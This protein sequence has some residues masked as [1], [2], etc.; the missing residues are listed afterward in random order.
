MGLNGSN[1]KKI[2]DTIFSIF[3][4]GAHQ[5]KCKHTCILIYVDLGFFDDKFALKNV[6]L[7]FY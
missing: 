7:F 2:L 3:P 6:D 4:A 5:F 1:Q